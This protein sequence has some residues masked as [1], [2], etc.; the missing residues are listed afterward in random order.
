[1]SQNKTINLSK[2]FDAKKDQYARKLGDWILSD[3]IAM[4]GD[5]ASF[6]DFMRNLGGLQFRVMVRCL[7]G[8]V[9]EWIGRQGVHSSAQDGEISGN[10]RPMASQKAGNLS[11]WTA[12]HGSKVNT[13]DGFGYRTLKVSGIIAVRVNDQDYLPEIGVLELRAAGIIN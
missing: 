11:F 10:G 7:D 1:M 13:G 12:T 2:V 6:W 8:T 5:T 3:N 4:M 9:R